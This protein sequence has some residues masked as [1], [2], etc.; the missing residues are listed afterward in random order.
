MFWLRVSTFSVGVSCIKLFRCHQQWAQGS[1]LAAGTMSSVSD[2]VFFWGC[3][4][5]TGKLSHRTG[6]PTLLLLLLSSPASFTEG[7]WAPL[8]TLPYLPLTPCRKFELC[9]DW[10]HGP[11]SVCG[12]NLENLDLQVLWIYCK[13]STSVHHQHFWGR[14]FSLLKHLHVFWGKCCCRCILVFK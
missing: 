11:G 5:H 13:I 6:S 9:L 4:H 1:A 8:E 12:M 7:S 10:V 3:L 14:F 2:W